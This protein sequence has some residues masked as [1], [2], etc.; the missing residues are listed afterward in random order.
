MVTRRGRSEMSASPA[1]ASALSEA[2]A[3]MRPRMTDL[4][5]ER[6]GGGN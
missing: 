3:V 5:R 4:L 6:G 1:I 2:Q